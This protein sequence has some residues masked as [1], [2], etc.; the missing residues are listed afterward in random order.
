MHRRLVVASLL[1][2]L[3]G[4]STF[5]ALNPFVGSGPK[6]AEL[7]SFK[8]SAEAKTVWRDSVGKADGYV[9]SPA[10]VGTSV[11]AADHDG[12]LVRLDDGKTVWRVKAGQDL[13]GGVAADENMVIVGSPKGELFAYAATDG[14]ALWSAKATSEVLAPAALGGGLVVVR[15]GDNRVAAY[16]M[17]TGKRKWIFQRPMPALALRVTAPP[18]IDGKYVFVGYAGGKLVALD[19]LNGAQAWEGTVALPKGATELERV[20]DVTST[21]VIS[22]R[23]ICAV[24]FQGRVACFDL[25]S[26]NLIWARDMSSSAGLAIDR[27]VLYVSDEKGAVHALD[28]ASGASLWKQDALSM[29]RLTAPLPYNDLVAVGDAEGVLHFLRRDDGA[30]AARITTDGGAVLTSLRKL[31]DN[32][33]L[34]TEK[35]GIFSVKAE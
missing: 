22:G 19:L 25:D 26:G 12:N 16:D 14:K 13:S 27:R 9:F 35:G 15:S 1:V 5:D 33:L 17:Q 20:A 18:L 8:P 4:C 11:Y 31:G 28:L 21:P 2:L 23:S 3:T 29:R 6:M 10:V 30:F 34:Q 32:V 24:A 7:K